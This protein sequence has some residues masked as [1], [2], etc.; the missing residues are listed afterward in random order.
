MPF[1]NLQN[2]FVHNIF[3][4]LG[5]YL[6]RYSYTHNT[7]YAQNVEII[8]KYSNRYFSITHLFYLSEL[9]YRNTIQDPR[10]ASIFDTVTVAILKNRAAEL[11]STL[12]SHEIEL[13][14]TTYRYYCIYARLHV[15]YATTTQPQNSHYCI[16]VFD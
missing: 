9:F 12:N 8:T 7:R 15:C 2:L 10:I 4:T 5:K 13:L 11:W 1:H 6:T 3:L 14:L 16:L